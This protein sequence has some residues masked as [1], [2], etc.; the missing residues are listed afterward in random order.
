ML[1]PGAVVEINPADL[2]G[3]GVGDGDTVAVVSGKARLQRTVRS[4]LKVPPGQVHLPF[5]GARGDDVAFAAAAERPAGWP[6]VARRLDG[7]EKIS[8]EGTS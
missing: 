3:L 2:G 1:F 8:G 4:D 7:I 5:D 6:A